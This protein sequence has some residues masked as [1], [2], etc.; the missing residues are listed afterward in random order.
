MQLVATMHS[1]R[2]AAVALCRSAVLALAALCKDRESLAEYSHARARA[3]DS[4]SC[5]WLAELIR[6]AVRGAG[7]RRS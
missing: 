3:A 6:R 7:P 4:P 1:V 5:A 2:E